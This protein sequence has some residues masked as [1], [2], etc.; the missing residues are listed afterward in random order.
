MPP[1][2]RRH[3]M[4]L[5]AQVANALR[6]EIESGAW[7]VGDQLPAID[8]LAARFGIAR[9]TMRQAIEVIE[10]EGLVLRRHGH[11]TFVEKDPRE[12]RWLPLASDWESFVRT[13]E[14]LQ[15]KLLLVEAAERQPRLL[16]GEGRPAA[17]YQHL[18]RIHYRDDRPFCAIDIHLAADIYLRAPEEFRNRIVVPVLAR[19]TEIG[20]ATV[21]QTLT[22][23]GANQNI[24]ELL[25]LPLG[26][27]VAC[28]R[29][30]I[31]NAEGTC[32]YLADVVYRG[33][34]VR[35]EIDL[36]PKPGET[37]DG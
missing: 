14:S 16:A 18:K 19:M 36:S 8:D 17:A 26:A 6:G 29:R 12:Q 2:A 9:A 30:T 27:P 21:K 5:Y 4:P 10:E 7:T 23:D 15:P 13:I 3:T 1:R 31:V 28:V 20:I 34:V 11:G 35:L 25:D 33:D 22:V 24:A 32:I 37:A